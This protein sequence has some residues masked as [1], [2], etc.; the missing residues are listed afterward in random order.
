MKFLDVVEIITQIWFMVDILISF[1][2]GYY[3]SGIIVMNRKL[4]VK[5]YL[6]RRFIL[7]ILATIPFQW[8]VILNSEVIYY[9]NCN[10]FNLN[11]N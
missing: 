2:T 7:D 3:Y 11:R 6:S 4:I 10:S 8:I 9:F 5:N 1:N